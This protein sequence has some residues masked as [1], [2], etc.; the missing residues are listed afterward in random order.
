MLHQTFRS[1][2]LCSLICALSACSGERESM[3]AAG[4][5]SAADFQQQTIAVFGASGSIGGLI[6]S[7]ALDRGH[8]VIGISRSPENLNVDHELFTARRGDVTSVESFR[9]MAQGVDA[10]IISVQGNGTNNLPENTVHALSAAT[11]AAALAGMDD[12]PYVLQIGGATTM[13]ETVEGILENSPY[14]AEEGSVI[15]AMLLGHLVA[16]NA[17]R[18]SDIDWTVLTPPFTIRGWSPEGI[19]D[20]TALRNY[21]T[22]T[23][24]FVLDY[25]GSRA[26]I[27]VADLAAA[28]VDEIENRNFVRQRFTAAN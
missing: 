17:Y 10:V 8:N 26:S 4:E 7:A 5:S 11:A 21:R 2:V 14:P 12:A 9:E 24:G 19:T 18:D 1:T 27:M 15:Y 13:F 28:A 6:V 25:D 23:S 16:L 3:P 22:S 20:T